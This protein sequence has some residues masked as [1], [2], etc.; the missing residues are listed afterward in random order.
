M[1]LEIPEHAADYLRQRATAAGYDDVEQYVLRRAF[2]DDQELAAMD[3]AARD[4]RATDL[5]MEG[6]RS[7][8]MTSWTKA[9]FDQLRERIRQQIGDQ[10]GKDA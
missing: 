6:L 9:E 3:A 7:G 10:N 4:P 1:H 8:P 5:I 2:F